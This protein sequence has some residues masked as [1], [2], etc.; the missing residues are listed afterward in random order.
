MGA[1]RDQVR[2]A[3][4]RN[5]Q[6]VDTQQGQHMLRSVWAYGAYPERRGRRFESLLKKL[7]C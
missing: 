7:Q 1:A 6:Q 3:A 5:K 4:N 2:L